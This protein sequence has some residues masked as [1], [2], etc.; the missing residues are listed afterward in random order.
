MWSWCQCGSV[1]T[2]KCP[3]DWH[4]WGWISSHQQHI[5]G[6]IFCTHATNN[7]WKRAQRELKCDMQWQ[8]LCTIHSRS[9]GFSTT[10]SLDPRN[11]L[12]YLLY[13]HTHTHT[14]TH[15]HTHTES[16]SPLALLDQSADIA[17][18]VTVV[19]RWKQ[20]AGGMSHM[21]QMKFP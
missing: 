3:T 8:A 10:V 21:K 14:C 13:T 7:K 9:N 20:V 18:F 4:D 16:C 6:W 11:T 15:T 2:N 5:H 12:D 1:P 17:V 19:A